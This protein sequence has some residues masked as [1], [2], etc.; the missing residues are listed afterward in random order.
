[1]CAAVA[2]SVDHSPQ[3]STWK[4]SAELGVPWSTMQ[5]HMKKVLN[6][7]P[8]RPT[9]TNE[10]SDI[11]MNRCCDAC[12][13]LLD[14]FRNTASHSKVLF[15]DGCELIAVP[16]TEMFCFWLWRIQISFHV[17]LWASMTATHLIGPY[18]F[19]GTVN[20]ASYA[21]MLQVWLIP[22]LRN[23]GLMENV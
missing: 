21:E 1:M 10:L 14:T 11:D 8:Y 7:K 4:Q 17:M 9:F 12:R 19:D 22:Q 13:A 18:F 23:R 5:D 2:T 6:L 15:T 3:K 20:A 16:V